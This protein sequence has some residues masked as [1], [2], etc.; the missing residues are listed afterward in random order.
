M[1]IQIDNES[2]AWYK[3]ELN[4]NKGDFVRFYARYGGDSTIQSGFSL[5][6]SKDEPVDIA[7]KIDKDGITYFI[8]EKDVWYFDEHDL[9]IEFKPEFNEPVFHYKKN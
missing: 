1:N 2:A 7:V 3:E 6:I 4:L 8:D 9:L 5:G